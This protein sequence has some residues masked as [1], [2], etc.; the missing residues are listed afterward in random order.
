[1]QHYQLDAKSMELLASTSGRKSA[2]QRSEDDGRPLK[3][4]LRCVGSEQLPDGIIKRKQRDYIETDESSSEADNDN[5][6]KSEQRK[7]PENGTENLENTDEKD[8]IILDEQQD[9]NPS[10]ELIFG[11]DLN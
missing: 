2:T 3:K 9:R 8:V 4:K 10:K 5:G 1:M 6:D 7:A 11:S